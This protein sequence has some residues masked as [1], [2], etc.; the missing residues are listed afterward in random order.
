[1][2]DLNTDTLPFVSIIM[3]VYNGERFLAESVDSVLMQTYHNFELIICNDASTDATHQIL[4][5]ITD[6]RVRVIQNV[7]NLGEGISRNRAIEVARGVW[8]A[9]IDSDDTWKPERLETLVS[10]TDKTQK[11]MIF[12]DIMECHDTLTGMVPWKV[13]RGRNAFG[14]NGITTV[15]VPM[16]KYINSK[17]LLIKPLFPLQ[18][19]KKNHIIHSQKKF[20]A[21][22][23]FFIKLLSCGL[24]LKYV[25][26]AMYCYRI[27]PGSA[28]SE[29]MRCKMM[30]GVLENAIG[31]Y[32]HSPNVQSALKKK[33]SILVREEKYMP[34]V[35][36]LKR[37]NI[38][39]AIQIVYRS[40]WVIPEFF[41]RLRP[42]LHYHVHR[43]WHGG[44]TRGIK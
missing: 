11:D 36:N 25:P 44:R 38:F 3:P 28:T 4:K 8:A 21:D 39:S 9:V 15:E 13:L 23:E 42:T 16:E 19:I 12:D 10:E 6:S 18:V 41:K 1:M 31:D 24:N 35:F 7:N 27:T 29:S 22:T 26:K 34:F 2:T 14:G 40:P 33:I 43:I 37:K 20:G 5:K 32:N 17:R 30:R